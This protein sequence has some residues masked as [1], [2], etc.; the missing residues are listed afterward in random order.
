MH[1]FD[2]SRFFVK[3]RASLAPALAAVWLIGASLAAQSVWPQGYATQPGGAALATP[4]SITASLQPLRTHAVVALRGASLPF[5]AGRKIQGLAFRRDTKHALAYASYAATV[6]VR[7]RVVADAAGLTAAAH[8]AFSA[9]DEVFN[10]S[11]LVPAAPPPVAGAAPF[12]LRIPFAK[13]WDYPGGDLAIEV[14]VDGPGRALWRC[15]AVE[16][17]V[18]DGGRVFNLLGGCPTSALAPA[19]LRA[20]DSRR[21][22]PGGRIDLVVDRLA[23]PPQGLGNVF[24]LGAASAPIDLGSS[25]DPACKLGVWPIALQATGLFGD[26]LPLHARAALAVALPNDATLAGLRF[27][28]QGLAIDA[29][30]TSAVPLA[31][32]QAIEVEVGRALAPPA[33]VGRHMW[34]HGALSAGAVDGLQLG[35]ANLVPVISFL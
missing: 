17:V 18:Q 30:L 22:Y 21:I 24:L 34:K 33:F 2:R 4:F 31:M 9:A 16:G 19:T 26:R 28:V 32:S 14:F 7:M 13:A 25:F 1:T 15:D 10:A 35:P 20:A 12:D 11:V 27:A 8:L 3:L 6:R 23:L 5:G 29:G